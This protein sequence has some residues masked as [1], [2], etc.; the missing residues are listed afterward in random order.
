MAVATS[1][2]NFR[3]QD[4]RVQKPQI[5]P[6]FSNIRTSLQRVYFDWILSV[7]STWYEFVRSCSIWVYWLL[8]LGTRT[9]AGLYAKK[10]D[11][12]IT[13]DFSYQKT[14]RF[15]AISFCPVRHVF[16]GNERLPK[17]GVSTSGGFEATFRSR[18]SA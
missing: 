18:K 14:R 16:S 4:T 5:Q 7:S 1:C 15:P 8:G 13:R 12:T 3:V 6:R 10:G 2:L 9:K 11:V 17:P